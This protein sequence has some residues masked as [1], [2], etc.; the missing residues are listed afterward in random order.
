[1]TFKTQ[2]QMLSLVRDNVPFTQNNLLT[3]T[4]SRIDGTFLASEAAIEFF[5]SITC[6]SSSL[7]FIY[8]T[9][10]GRKQKSQQQI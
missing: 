10:L 2:Q 3:N 9:V 5:P 1:M 7:D 6:W 4:F 8:F